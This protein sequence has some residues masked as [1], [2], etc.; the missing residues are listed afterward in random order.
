MDR[1]ERIGD[2]TETLR[3]AM[4]GA[5]AEIWTAMP[6]IVQS[7]D[8]AVMTAVVQP[9]V[10]GRIVDERGV[11]SDVDLPL[12]PDVPVVF[13][14]GGGFTLTFPIKPGDECLVVFGS[15][16][17]DGWWQGG[18]VSPAP[19][20]RMHD[21]SDGFALVGPRSRAG[22]L[23]SVDIEYTQLRSDD[24]ETSITVQPTK[25]VLAAQEV[26]IRADNITVA[27]KD[28]GNAA[29]DLTGTMGVSGDLSLDGGL[30]SL[31]SHRH[32]GVQPGSGDTGTPI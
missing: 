26:E 18:Q 19:D 21:L 28:G 14:A 4:E 11:A 12:L 27:G 5:Q 10:Q 15:R 2:M 20:Q 7:Y 6:G 25:I 9:A 22:A 24:G 31:R 29:V 23:A 17:I 3:S 16:C 1:R 30:A 32:S 13:P 8:P